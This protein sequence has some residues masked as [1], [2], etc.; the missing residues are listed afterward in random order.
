MIGD[1]APPSPESPCP[2]FRDDPGCLQDTHPGLRPQGNDQLSVVG[3]PPPRPEAPLRVPT[4]YRS[5]L[6]TSFVVA[7]A[8]FE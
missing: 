2:S 1:H 5:P 6:Q 7:L 8:S 4:A 3:D